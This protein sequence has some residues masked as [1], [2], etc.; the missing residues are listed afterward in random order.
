MN[1]ENTKN[2]KPLI[3]TKKINN[4]YKVVPLS[5]TTNTSGPIRHFPP[6]TKEWFNSIYAF[7]NNTIKNLSIA[8]K[9]IV[10]LIKSYFNLYFSKEVLKSKHL[11]T[12]FR[13]LSV[14]KIFVSKAELK[15]TSS[16][17]VIT[18][19]V[20][21][22]ERRVLISKLKRLEAI[23]FPFSTSLQDQMINKNKLLSLEEKLDIIKSQEKNASLIN[24]LQVLKSY[25]IE[26][27]KLEENSLF[28]TKRTILIK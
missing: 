12:R 8:D 13:R 20:Y 3:F 15:H 1:I 27:I 4:K 22:E 17:V 11:A 14:N 23:L 9:N 10:K 6:A 7:N 26:Q 2:I 24:W 5:I 28:L 25:I 16:K 18:L 21:N 19:Y